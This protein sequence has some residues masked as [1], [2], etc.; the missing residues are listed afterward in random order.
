MLKIHE[1]ANSAGELQCVHLK[2]EGNELVL[3]DSSR[4]VAIEI[5]LPMLYSVFERYGKPL[6]DDV[7]PEGA[8]LQLCEQASLMHFRHLAR[9][10][11][12]ARDFLVLSR[13]GQE[14]LVELSVSIA[15]AL[16]HLTRNA[17]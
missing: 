7:K 14:A 15:G 12:I 2:V 5:P 4:D 13:E 17:S 3:I 10:D 11:V 9:F 6:A 8:R 1:F 16:L